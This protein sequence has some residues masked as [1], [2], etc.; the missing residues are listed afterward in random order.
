MNL[1]QHFDREEIDYLGL[2][3]A[4]SLYA[5]PRDKIRTLLRSGQLI[6]VKKG[7]YVF[8]PEL[9]VGPYCKELLANLIYGPSCISLEY[10]LGFY[11]LIPERVETVTSVTNKRDKRFN[12]PVGHFSYRYLHSKKYSIQITQQTLDEQ[13][14]ILIAS[15]EKA[16]ADILVLTPG[17]NLSNQKQ[18]E[19]FLFEDLRLSENALKI[20][21]STNILELAATYKNQH[22]NMLM[23]LVK[24]YE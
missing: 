17:L 2:M 18:L 9:A 21:D 22:I 10:A 13:H 24:K 3:D 19:H 20:M 1:R 14:P 12:T 4:L 5:K 15:K 7:L 8:G 6:R 23:D 16:L 11:G